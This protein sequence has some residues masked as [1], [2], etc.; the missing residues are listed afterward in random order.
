MGV[1]SRVGLIVWL[2][3]VGCTGSGSGDEPERKTEPFDIQEVQPLTISEDSGGVAFRFLDRP[4]GEMKT[5]LK[6]DDV[7]EEVR[8]AVLAIDLSPGASHHPRAL[9]V[10]DLRSPEP[11]GTFRVRVVDRFAYDAA[12]RIER[13]AREKAAAEAPPVVMFSAEWC[14]ACKQA[15][16]WLRKS[17]IPFLE[18]DIEKDPGARTALADAARQAG[19]NPQSVAGSVP[20]F[21]VNG[22]V[23]KGFQPGAIQAA[24]Q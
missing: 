14:G 7:P 24:L 8:E 15:A 22:K 1:R 20:V 17:G 4:S 12:K 6:R 3:I 18:R 13:E 23:M 5:V 19:M 16:K 9:F 11:D 10:A 21:L 2:G